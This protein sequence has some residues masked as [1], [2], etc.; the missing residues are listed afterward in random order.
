MRN[1]IIGCS[2]RIACSTRGIEQNNYLG[3]RDAIDEDMTR[4]YLSIRIASL[5]VLTRT[6][7]LCY[8]LHLHVPYV[9]VLCT[10]VCETTRIRY[11]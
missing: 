2:K 1:Q 7:L 4:I 10:F 3:I 9:C 5:H 6:S 8:T 11:T